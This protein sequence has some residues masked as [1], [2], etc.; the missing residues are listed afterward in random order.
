MASA[1]LPKLLRED[2][3]RAQVE[4]ETFSSNPAHPFWR[5]K[6]RFTTGL[7]PSMERIR[8]ASGDQALDFVCA[9]YPFADRRRCELLGRW[10]AESAPIDHKAPVERSAPVAPMRQAPTHTS[11]PPPPL[12]PTPAS[13]L[14]MMTKPVLGADL[15]RLPRDSQGRAVLNES[16]LPRAIAAHEGGL[17]WPT[18]AGKL[19]C[20]ER[21]LRER[22]AKWRK[23]Q[24]PRQDAAQALQASV[25]SKRQE[26]GPVPEGVLMGGVDPGREVLVSTKAP[27][28]TAPVAE[29][30]AEL[31][32]AAM[33]K[34]RER[35]KQL[36]L[37]EMRGASEGLDRD[38]VA[39]GWRKIKEARAAE[40]AGQR[41]SPKPAASPPAATT[42]PTD[43]RLWDVLGPQRHLLASR[44]SSELSCRLMTVLS[45]AGVECSRVASLDQPTPAPV[46][47][48]TK[49]G[50][51]T[52]QITVNP[53]ESGG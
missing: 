40:A 37:Q 44:Q 38:V 35:L 6:V 29:A 45:A 21:N 19:G 27:V 4:G 41:P 53:I 11:K 24:Q 34:E 48:P 16:V 26:G 3:K 42:D 23:R 49:A 22:A 30:M 31:E 9:R 17:S 43:S 52:V 20:A 47:N 14:A 1:S 13:Q 18:I 8:A 32:E 25:A 12:S 15:K 36:A 7:K 2:N 33:A 5:V 46:I 39:A 51:F 50:G 28:V 10:D